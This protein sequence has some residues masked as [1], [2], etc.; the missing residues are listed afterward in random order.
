MTPSEIA[1]T[2]AL[3]ASFLTALGSLGV[4][5]FQESRRRK[6]NEKAA[7]RAAVTELMSRSLSVRM[8]ARA[9][10]EA[11]KVSPLERQRTRA[12][13]HPCPL[14]LSSAT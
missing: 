14:L 3:G 11:M 9:L 8:R 2:A 4:V 1:V 10:G 5:W 13:M 6:A 7:L 12:T